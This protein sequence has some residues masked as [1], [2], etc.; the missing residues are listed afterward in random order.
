MRLTDSA[1]AAVLGEI[2]VRQV[3]PEEQAR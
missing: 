1:E 2:T 3:R